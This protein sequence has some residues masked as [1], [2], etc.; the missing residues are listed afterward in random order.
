MYI[1]I[2]YVVSCRTEPS[3]KIFSSKYPYCQHYSLDNFLHYVCTAGQVDKRPLT[4]QCWR[5][6]NGKRIRWNRTK[7]W[8]IFW[9]KAAPTFRTVHYIELF[10]KFSLPSHAPHDSFQLRADM[11]KVEV[12]FCLTFFLFFLP[13][14]FFFISPPALRLPPFHGRLRHRLPC[15]G[16]GE[17]ICWNIQPPLADY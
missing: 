6:G 2:R 17:Y 8:Q 11:V 12:E 15:L 13:F 3:L 7:S 16:S 14:S 1:L 9:R 5:N 10:S 4:L